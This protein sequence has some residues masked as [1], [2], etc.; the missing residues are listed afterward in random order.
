M[1]YRCGCVR[2]W[3]GNYEKGES[4]LR[5]LATKVKGDNGEG[6]LAYASAAN[7]LAAHLLK[8]KPDANT[9]DR[10]KEAL[11]LLQ[12]SWSVQLAQNGP[13]H[14]LTQ[15][16]HKNICGGG[17]CCREPSAVSAPPGH[18]HSFFFFFSQKPVKKVRTPSP[19]SGLWVVGRSRA[20]RAPTENWRGFVFSAPAGSTDVIAHTLNPFF[21]KIAPGPPKIKSGAQTLFFQK[22]PEN[23]PETSRPKTKR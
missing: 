15:D 10:D 23:P 21:S 14:Y 17:A 12:H 6:S 5:A 7:N 16:A 2:A 20:A 18:G 4:E 22:R 19:C 3:G 8:M 1:R 11:R 13:T 9:T